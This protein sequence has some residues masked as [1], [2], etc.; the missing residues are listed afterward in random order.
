MHIT[1]LVINLKH[2]QSKIF[3]ILG[4]FPNINE[5]ISNPL[6]LMRLASSPYVSNNCLLSEFIERDVMIWKI[7]NFFLIP[8]TDLKLFFEE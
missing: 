8:S 3:P 5:S 2:C 7:S 1:T 6:A 4:V